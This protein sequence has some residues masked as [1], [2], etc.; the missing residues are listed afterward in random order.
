MKILLINIFI[1]IGT[2][3]VG[4]QTLVP[5][6]GGNEKL[7]I[8]ATDIK[9]KAVNTPKGKNKASA[10]EKASHPFH[11]KRV[12]QTQGKVF[13][14]NGESYT[15]TAGDSIVFSPGFE[16]DS[17]AEFTAEIKS[18]PAETPVAVISE[19]ASEKDKS[20]NASSKTVGS[21]KFFTLF[22]NPASEQ[23]NIEYEVTKTAQVSLALYTLEGTP[24]QTF[25]APKQQ[26][27]GNYKLAL[28]VSKIPSGLYVI[29][30]KIHNQTINQR[31][32]LR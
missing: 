7:I 28:P 10:N 22:P 27:P 9:I 17:T 31:I 23:F 3:Q 11:A 1:I 26:E 5:T 14:T 30:L 12:I 16:V 15:F 19:S 18:V 20:T 25:M 21:L 13:L 4:A 29:S 24:V 6:S 32:V 2:M 8:T